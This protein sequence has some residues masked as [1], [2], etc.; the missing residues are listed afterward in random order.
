M[1]SVWRVSVSFSYMN[2]TSSDAA[3]IFVHAFIISRVDNCSSVFNTVSACH[4]NSLQSVLNAVARLITKKRKFDPISVTLQDDRHWLP[5]Q[6][7]I[8]LNSKHAF[9]FFKCLHSVAHVY[10]KE[11]CWPVS[12]LPRRRHLHSVRPADYITGLEYQLWTSMFRHVLSK[13]LES[14]A[15]RLL[16]SYT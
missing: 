10:L 7:R 16:K 11:M 6:H 4:L 2:F 15:T 3:K 9:L 5:I 14:A 12:F 13:I 1:S 8:E